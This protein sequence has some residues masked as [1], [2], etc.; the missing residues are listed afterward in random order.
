MAFNP[1]KVKKLEV[2]TRRWYIG[3]LS[4]P[5]IVSYTTYQ[6]DLGGFKLNPKSVILNYEGLQ[7]QREF[8]SPLY[9]SKNPGENRIPDQRYLLFWNPY[10][11][12]D[13]NGHSQLEFN[14]SD[15]PG[16]YK[17]VVEGMVKD[18]AVGS[19]SSTFT[20]K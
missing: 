3:S 7:Q 5:G 14:T 8:Y 13:A 12:L 16:E 18:G 4:F 20:V 19:T 17:I 1:R 15:I 11:T 9:D 6:G 2:T 10:T